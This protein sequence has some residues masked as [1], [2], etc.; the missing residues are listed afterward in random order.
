MPVK[1]HFGQVTHIYSL[2]NKTMRRLI[3]F[4]FSIKSLYSKM[5]MYWKP[6]LLQKLCVTKMTL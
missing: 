3:I 4:K 1:V 2:Q 5:D 6:L